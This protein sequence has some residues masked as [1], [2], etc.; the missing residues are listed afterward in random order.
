MTARVLFVDDEPRVLDGIRRLL[1]GAYDVEVAEG[2]REGL[3]A[4]ERHSFAVIVSDMMM[5]EI[6]GPE[7]LALAAER[8]PDAV[9]M[10]LSGQADLS[11]TVA[12][13]NDGNLFRFLM[14]PVD[15]DAL[16]AALAA[17]IE[18][19]RLRTV[20]R[21]LL[22]QTLSGAVDALGEVLAMASPQSTRRS[23][24]I[25]R[26]VQ[27]IANGTEFD[28]DWQMNV[29]AMLANIGAISVPD[30]VLD[31]ASSGEFLSQVESQM[32]ARHP[33]LAADL[34]LRIPRMDGVA[35]IVRAQH[36][37]H[38]DEVRPELADRARILQLAVELTDCVLRGVPEQ[39]AIVLVEQSERFPAALFERLR[40]EPVRTRLAELSVQDLRSGMV[41]R[42]PL[43]TPEGVVIANTGTA[44]TSVLIA[45][46]ANF[47][48]G[49]GVCEPIVVEVTLERTAV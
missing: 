23:S 32:I 12:A 45:R 47:A 1:R 36:G 22:E 18:H 4:L 49:V 39:D 10:I 29:A 41:L 26:Y 40:N 2:G 7:F 6:K 3:A 28:E 48:S 15:R 34:I 13:V 5:P 16:L 24:M 14:K 30:D 42:G 37:A 31:R 35:E 44:L 8:Q 21:D 27:L 38:V 46:I 9:Q 20:E 25:R 19:H 33:A 17:A 43:V 11:S